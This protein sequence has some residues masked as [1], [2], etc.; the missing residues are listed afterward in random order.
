MPATTASLGPRQKLADPSL[1]DRQM[2][3][4]EGRASQARQLTTIEISARV[5]RHAKDQGRATGLPC[6]CEAG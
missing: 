6:G 5:V 3:H 1:D 4:C 2:L